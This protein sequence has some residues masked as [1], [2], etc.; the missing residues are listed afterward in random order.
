MSYKFVNNFEQSIQN[1]SSKSFL[2]V[3]NFPNPKTK[4]YHIRKFVIDGDNTLTS[5]KDY[6][7]NKSTYDKLLNKKKNNEY[8]LYAVHDLNTV[9]YPTQSDILVLK[10]DILSCNYDYYGE[11]PF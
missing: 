6:F 1:P 2:Q 5:Y 7:L 8:K 11:A 4:L 3:A 9:S 10:S